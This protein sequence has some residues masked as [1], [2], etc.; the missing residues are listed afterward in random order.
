MVDSKNHAGKR[1]PMTS[2]LVNKHRY[3]LQSD[4][5]SWLRGLALQPA[6]TPEQRDLLVGLA[7][8]IQDFIVE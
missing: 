4:L 3:L 6:T 8:A 7:N 1:S 2:V 5:I